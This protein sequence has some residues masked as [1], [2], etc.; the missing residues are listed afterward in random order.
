MAMV[1]EFFN[2]MKMKQ[3][4]CNVFVEPHQINEDRA[5]VVVVSELIKLMK[6]QCV[7]S[8]SMLFVLVVMVFVLL[9]KM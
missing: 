8:L 3:A 9:V 4:A 2:S 6:V 1:Q 7:L 5:I